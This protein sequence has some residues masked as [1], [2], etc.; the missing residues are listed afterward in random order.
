L[1]WVLNG[2]VPSHDW[3]VIIP[4]KP[5][6]SAKSRLPS[7]P[8]FAHS[9]LLDVISAVRGSS[10][11][12]HIRVVTADPT[13]ADIA[14]AQN[15]FITVEAAPDG[16]NQAVAQAALEVPPGHGIAVI[17]GD[18]PCLTPGALN[19]ALE[20]AARVEV[21]FV[22]DEAG[23]GS[24]MWF[25]RKGG[26]IETHFGER[27]RAAHRASGA[28]EIDAEPGSLWSAQL[29]RDVDTEVDLWDAI[30]IGVGRN[31]ADV[32]TARAAGS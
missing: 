22:S 14:A 30:R 13:V 10:E 20:T 8:I 26:P 5:F 9:F 28:T 19:V 31:T 4:V 32:V 11:V 12:S 24:T 25:S 6:A 23:T 16:I 18:L 1:L 3:S 2:A 21:A 29:H 15:C 7:G 27:S 17:L